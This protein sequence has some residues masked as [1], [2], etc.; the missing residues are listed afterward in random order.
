[1]KEIVL[2]VLVVVFPILIYFMYSIDNKMIEKNKNNLYFEFCTLSSI[3]LLLNISSNLICSLYLNSFLIIFYYKKKSLYAL[4]ISIL[5]LIFSF[6]IDINYIILLIPYIIYFILYKKNNKYLIY[7]I[8]IVSSIIFL[9]IN[10]INL[11]NINIIISFII[12]N[13]ILIKILNKID[14]TFKLYQ[15]LEEVHNDKLISSSLFKITH[16]IKNPLAVCKGYLDMYDVSNISHSKKYIPIIK[17]EIE[18]TLVIL[19]DFLS[20][21]KLNMN[22]DIIDINMLLE[23]VLN[24]LDILFKKN[25]I[26]IKSNILDKEIYIDADYNRLTQVFVNIL[27]NSI[28]SIENNGLIELNDYI[29]KNNIVIKIKDNGVGIKDIEKIKEPFFTTKTNGTGLGVPLSLEIIKKHNGV[30]NY[31]SNNKGTLVTI[32]L[33]II[34]FDN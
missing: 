29:E 32:K 30:I 24:N 4:L 8:S 17:E 26:K 28:E 2:D 20:I 34:C 7:I 9:I 11:F 1:M 23:Q 19:N 3:Y 10:D 22:K 12:L 18:R 25:N 13:I 31:D 15:T 21:S 5:T 33:P 6:Y 16:E 27:K 14:N